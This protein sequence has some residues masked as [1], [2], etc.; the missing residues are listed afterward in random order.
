MTV[1]TAVEFIKDADYE[2]ERGD[3][4]GAW[5]IATE[6]L[7]YYPEDA[8]L[9]KYA[10]VLAPPKVTVVP[11]DPNVDVQANLDWIKQNRGKY[12]GYW[13]AIKNGHFLASGKDVDELVDQIGE[14]K[15][16]GILVT[17]IY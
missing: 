9:K 4:H 6:G 8:L 11:R 7:Q 12:R 16:T 1:K 10:Y 15:N 3:W 17:P 14:I 2:L 5:K 13:V